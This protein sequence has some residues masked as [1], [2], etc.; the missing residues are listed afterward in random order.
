MCKA[1]V[2]LNDRIFYLA[3]LLIF[4]L[5]IVYVKFR[6]FCSTVQLLSFL[7]GLIVSSSPTKAPLADTE[8][9]LSLF[10]H[11]YQPQKLH[12]SLSL[13]TT[14]QWMK[15]EGVSSQFVLGL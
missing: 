7:M 2:H 6:S 4:K 11:L 3:V 10:R 5:K 12:I 8:H 9:L 1:K 14:F 13:A 15:A